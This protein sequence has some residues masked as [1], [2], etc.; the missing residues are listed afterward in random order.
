MDRSGRITIIGIATAALALF[1]VM[2]VSIAA[3]ADAP[4]WHIIAT[5]TDAKTDEQAKLAYKPKDF[6]DENECQQFRLSPEFQKDLESLAGVIAPIIKA[7]P[8]ASLN[9]DCEQDDDSI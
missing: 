9:F 3:H 5:V 2:A 7:H 6:A 1:A 4:R 8:D